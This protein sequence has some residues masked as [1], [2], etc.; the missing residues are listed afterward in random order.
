MDE[1]AQAFKCLFRKAYPQAQINQEAE[2][3]GRGV[4]ASQLVTGLR[5]D[6]KVRL[7]GLEGDVDHLLVRA[8]FEEAKLLDLGNGVGKSQPEKTGTL[9]R[10]I[11]AKG[12][13]QPKPLS[14]LGM[15]NAKGSAPNNVCFSCGGSGHFA[16]NCL[17]RVRGGHR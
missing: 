15:L 10:F 2:T 5:S 1:F 12:R 9:N 4:L 6:L 14:V 3:M 17:Y 8:R 7:A 13:T 11:P 16:R